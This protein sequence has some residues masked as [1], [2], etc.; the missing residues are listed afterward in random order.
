MVSFENFV[1]SMT[2]SLSEVKVK[3]SFCFP[4]KIP[5][6]PTATNNEHPESKKIQKL[7]TVH[8]CLFGTLK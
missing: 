6:E 1:E 7:I 2:T 8:Y 5:D 3:P 4:F